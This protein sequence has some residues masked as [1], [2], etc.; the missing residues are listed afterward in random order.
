[1]FRYFEPL[2]EVIRDMPRPPE[3]FFRRPGGECGCAAGSEPR[4]PAAASRP[5]GAALQPPLGSEEKS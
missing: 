2:Y 1:M 4:L 5:P 3:G